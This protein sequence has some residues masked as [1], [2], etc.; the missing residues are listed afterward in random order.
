[1]LPAK[2]KQL[3]DAFGS[4]RERTVWPGRADT[5]F[6]GK[7]RNIYSTNNLDTRDP[8]EDSPPSPASCSL[9]SVI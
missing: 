6:Q 7:R 1:M 9:L 5:S 2:G 4:V 3:G 8:G